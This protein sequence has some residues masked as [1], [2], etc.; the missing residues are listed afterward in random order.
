MPGA[1]LLGN[2][3]P[4]APQDGSLISFV[5]RDSAAGL[6]CDF[7]S[8]L[9]AQGGPTHPFMTYTQVRAEKQLRAWGITR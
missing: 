4:P 8:A 5:D 2:S 9:E 1:S 3:Q 6:I 7:L